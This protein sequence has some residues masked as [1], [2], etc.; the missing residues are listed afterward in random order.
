MRW[1]WWLAAVVACG[2]GDEGTDGG[3][4]GF[5]GDAD[6]CPP[7]DPAEDVV[8]A[9]QAQVEE[10]VQD[11]TH[12]YWADGEDY[13]LHR[14][15]KDGSGAEVLA[16][17]RGVGVIANVA[18]DGGFVWY[19]EGS[20]GPWSVSRVPVGGGAPERLADGLGFMWALA[21][22]DGVAYVAHG[23]ASGG[24]V[25]D[26]VSGGG[27]STRLADVGGATFGLA[28][29]DGRLWWTAIDARA[30]VRLH[31]VALDGGPVDD[32][33]ETQCQGPLHPVGDDL[34][35]TSLGTVERLPRGGGTAEVV[36][37]GFDRSFEDVAVADGWVYAIGA[38]T[39]E[40]L[41]LRART[42]GADEELLSCAQNFPRSVLVDGDTVYV[43]N[44]G[45]PSV[46][47]TSGGITKIV[48]R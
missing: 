27:G 3:P 6:T 38:P 45:G 34:W 19:G 17:P 30:G 44:S 9:D 5:G 16:S 26:A 36:L 15:R 10:L 31:S 37:D 47:E 32:G 28:I 25:I 35:C 24:Q 21:A 1:W 11:A 41:V 4:A 7:T 23:P 48:L 12:L 40:G 29:A 13:A 43:G 22:Q 46:P 20:L 18:V 14:V 2:E 42:S 33:L 39:A 8:P